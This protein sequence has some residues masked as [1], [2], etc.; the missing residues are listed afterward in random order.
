VIAGLGVL[1]G[2]PVW[3]LLMLAIVVDS[4]GPVF[5]QQT[6]VGKDGVEFGMFKFRSMYRDADARLKELEAHNEATGPL[7]KMK[8]D[9][10]VTRVGKWMRKFSI[11]EFPQLLGQD[12]QG[13]T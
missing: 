4:R 1:I 5:Y 9:P 12:G 8:N 10:R 6:R 2:L 3:L 7:F 13:L 11:D